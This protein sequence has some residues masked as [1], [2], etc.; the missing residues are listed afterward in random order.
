MRR[1]SFFGSSV[2]ALT[3]ILTLAA[4]PSGAEL[5]T[6]TSLADSGPGTL[7]EALDAAA[8]SPGPTDIQFA[9][10]GTITLAGFLPLITEPVHMIG[11]ASPGDVIIDGAGSVAE[12]LFFAFN[13]GGSTLERLTFRNFTQTVMRVRSPNVS[14]LNN[15]ILASGTG[16][17][18]ESVPFLADGNLID[19]HRFQGIATN[20]A[21][22]STIRNNTISNNL[23]EGVSLFQIGNVLVEGNTIVGNGSHGVVTSFAQNITLRNNLVGNNGGNG[24]FLNRLSG[25]ASRVEGNHVGVD[26]AG[27]LMPNGT[28]PAVFLK[29]GVVIDFSNG[30]GI[31]VKGNVIGGNAGDGIYLS[32]V[33]GL[34]IFGNWIGVDPAGRNVGNLENGIRV[35]TVSTSHQ[36]GGSR[37]AGE[38]NIIGFNHLRGLYIDH[39]AT[40]GNLVEGNWIGV[41]PAGVKAFGNLGRGIDFT[42]SNNRIGHA[43]DPDRINTIGNNGDDGIYYQGFILNEILGNFIGTDELAGVWGNG[44]SGIRAVGNNAR[45]LGNTIAYNVGDGVRVPGTGTFNTILGGS[46]RDNGVM[47]IN[48]D[49]PSGTPGNEGHPA[50]TNLATGDTPT[51]VTLAGDTVAATDRIEIFASDGDPQNA[52]RLVTSF[53]AST[54]GGTH[55]SVVIPAGPDYD[56]TV[57]NAYVAT[58]TGGLTGASTSELASFPSTVPPVSPSACQVI[59][60]PDVT[61]PGGGSVAIEA[62]LCCGPGCAPLAPAPV[63]CAVGCTRFASGTEWLNINPGEVV[64]VAAGTTFTGGVNL[65]GGELRSCG[66]SRPNNVNFNSGLMTNLGVMSLAWLNINGSASAFENY[67]YLDAQGIGFQGLFAN[68]GVTRLA[69]D[70]NV[71]SGAVFTNSGFFETPRSLNNGGTATNSGILTLGD[72]LRNNGSAHFTNRA[73]IL[74]GRD[75]SVDASFADDGF[76]TVGNATFLNSPGLTLADGAQVETLDLYVNG[77]V[78]GGEEECSRLQVERTTIINSS[79]SVSG[80]ID[81]CDVTGIETQNGTLGPDVTLDCSC[82]L[83][84]PDP[85]DLSFEWS[86]AASLSDP[87]SSSPVASPATTTEFTVE[88]SGPDGSL[89]EGSVTVTVSP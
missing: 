27:T 30:S 43:T 37:T 13:G 9:V 79:G 61:I 46:L 49:F 56:P 33:S 83:P 39:S 75:F 82:E 77:E 40:T 23:T 6:V 52:L 69:N 35:S 36:I 38:G 12:C 32:R 5:I 63:S 71:G 25:T 34:R 42:G 51:Q 72:S 76:I 2:L 86:P 65:N 84:S 47:A 28:S 31:V 41:D 74:V 59:T 48:L 89:G 18:A 15:R 50:P 29:A 80:E 87:A 78:K 3:L 16:I 73:T 24:F 45:I 67:G 17:T 88:V 8:A 14:F 21:D 85:S 81:L 11:G 53:V 22:G 1:I 20:G 68:F 64:C 54:A 26:S 62:G 19:G 10:T 57:V 4:A 66:E 60:S 58:S 44:G 55:W 70:F 7:R